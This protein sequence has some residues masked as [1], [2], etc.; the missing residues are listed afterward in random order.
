MNGMRGTSV[1]FG[2]K[3]ISS[4]LTTMKAN[5]NELMS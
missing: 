4:S 2:K 1:K 3:T 5:K